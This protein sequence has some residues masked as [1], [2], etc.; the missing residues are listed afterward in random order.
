VTRARAGAVQS[1]AGAI[2]SVGRGALSGYNRD[3]QWS[4]YWIMDLV[5]EALPAPDLFARV[6]ATLRPDR[7]ALQR[8][9]SEEFVAAVDLADFLSNSRG[10]E[11]RRI[12][13]VVGEAVMLDLEAGQFRLDTVNRLL[14]Q[15]RID[16][17]LT[18][19]ELRSVVDPVAAVRGRRSLGGP[20]PKEVEAQAR[21][22]RTAAGRA[23]RWVAARRRALESADRRLSTL[24]K[25]LSSR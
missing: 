21:E 13:H 4:K 24:I 22:L 5:E 2:A 23:E 20:E 9:A 12:Y 19:G 14:R 15:A 1:L 25:Q 10:V 8:T 16:P 18:A 3:S 11:F 6:I 17:P 7:E